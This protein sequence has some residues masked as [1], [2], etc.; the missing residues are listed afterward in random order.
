M[1][2]QGRTVRGAGSSEAKS[3]IHQL[4]GG[5]ESENSRRS[6]F[7][8]L[9]PPV[10]AHSA[11]RLDLSQRATRGVT[12]HP[13]KRTFRRTTS[14]HASQTLRLA[15]SQPRRR[16]AASSG[17]RTARRPIETTV[18]RTAM[19]GTALLQRDGTRPSETLPAQKKAAPHSIPACATGQPTRLLALLDRSVPELCQVPG[20]FFCWIILRAF[21]S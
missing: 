20:V 4:T 19:A 5:A 12:A 21:V 9:S 3:S 15:L 13:K 2:V 8:G 10:L 16:V 6:P 14:A 7:S 17:L 1:L 11:S 18:S